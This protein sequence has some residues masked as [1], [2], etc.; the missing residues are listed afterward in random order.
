MEFFSPSYNVYLKSGEL[1]DFVV[2]VAVELYSAGC[3]DFAYEVH[4]CPFKSKMESARL[5]V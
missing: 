5:V 3:C 2:V 4:D 1:N